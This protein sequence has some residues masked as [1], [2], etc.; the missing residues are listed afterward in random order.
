MSPDCNL[1]TAPMT[2]P[3]ARDPKNTPPTVQ[4]RRSPNFQEVLLRNPSLAFVLF[5]LAT[6][7][8]ADEWRK[9]YTVS[10]KGTVHVATNDG[11]VQVSTWDGKQ[12]EVN[13]ETIG[14]K[15]DNNEVRIIENQIGNRLDFE[16]RV[17]NLNWN[18][19]N[20]RRSL[21]ITLKVPREADLNVRTGD[22]NV[23]TDNN[24]G[25]ID[26]RTG[27]GRITIRGAKGAI[28]LSTGDGDINAT[29]LDGQLDAT[30]G[31]GTIRVEGRFDSLNLRTSDGPI[32]AVVSKESRMLTSWNVRTGDGSVTLRLPENLQADLDVD[33]GDGSIR[34]DV[35]VV[36]SR[37]TDRSE[38]RGKLN[39]GGLALTVRTSDGSVHIM[40]N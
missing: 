32:D 13:V 40:K 1:F 8:Q 20:N 15:I 35:P 27:D 14:W 5:L 25:A 4:F 18:I 29:A 39:G 9:T 22:G 26:I 17:P 31:D 6:P 24:I 37:K 28:R 38:L 16:A 12:I 19:V 21:R 3:T 30:S 34:A 2:A 10:G 23:E 11:N 36:V 33:T 7:L